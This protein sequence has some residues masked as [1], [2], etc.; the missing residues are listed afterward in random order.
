MDAPPTRGRRGTIIAAA[1]S[2][3][4]AIAA[5]VVL[6][7]GLGPSGP[8]QPAVAGDT[9]TSTSSTPADETSRSAPESAALEPAAPGP[10]FGPILRASDPTG[11]K[12]P[13][14]GVDATSLI[15]LGLDEAGVLEAPTD[16]DDTG[17]YAGGPGPGDLGPF[18]VGAHVDS[19][20]GPAV[21]YRLGDLR[22]GDQVEVD[23][24]DGTVATYVIDQISRYEKADFPTVL[25]YGNVARAEIRLITCGGAFDTSA[26]HYVDNI[27]AFGHL[28]PA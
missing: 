25:V 23:R 18:V 17:W 26:G 13:A 3:V 14:I 16:Y 5:V 19:S 7:L 24:E 27:V 6:V 21:F 1:A 2:V 12:I 11:L 28:L 10:D 4:L 9:S 8:P 15:R 20:S 22:E